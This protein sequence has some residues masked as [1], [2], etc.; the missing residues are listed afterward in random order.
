MAQCRFQPFCQLISSSPYSY[1][2][3]PLL[4]SNHLSHYLLFFCLLL[5]FFFFLLSCGDICGGI[6][7]VWLLFL[8]SHTS[9][10]LLSFDWLSRKCQAAVQMNWRLRVTSLQRQSFYSVEPKKSWDALACDRFILP[11]TELHYCY[12]SVRHHNLYPL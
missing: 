10:V 12:I 3:P 5:T 4:L 8:R 11:E 7:D 9:S 2:P 1:T 6:I